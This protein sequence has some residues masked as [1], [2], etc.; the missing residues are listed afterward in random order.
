MQVHWIQ[1][2]V[3]TPGCL[4]LLKNQKRIQNDLL[5]LWRTPS[6][7]INPLILVE[8]IKLITHYSFWILKI[9]FWVNAKWIIGTLSFSEKWV[10]HYWFHL[11]ELPVMGRICS[12]GSMWLQMPRGM[13]L[14]AEGRERLKSPL[15]L[16][17]WLWCGGTSWHAQTIL[18]GT[19]LSNFPGHRFQGERVK[20]NC[21]E[22]LNDYAS[23]DAWQVLWIIGLSVD[24]AYSHT[25]TKSVGQF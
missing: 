13:V 4:V 22:W 12:L 2:L 18:L 1:C 23:E 7:S 19:L 3:L 9:E 10:F 6:P 11:F 16:L 25:K 20:W 17:L 8:P 5:L 24:A 15:H 21:V 14:L